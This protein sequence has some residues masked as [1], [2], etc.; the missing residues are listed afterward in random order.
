MSNLLSKI[1]DFH[2]LATSL[3]LESIAD[4]LLLIHDHILPL[5]PFLWN[6]SRSSLYE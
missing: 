2:S 6:W 5:I 4:S 1:I 3:S